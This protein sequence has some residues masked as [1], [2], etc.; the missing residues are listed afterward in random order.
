MPACPPWSRPCALADFL[1][2]L[3]PSHAIVAGLESLPDRATLAAMVRA[4]GPGRL[5]FSL[6]MQAGQPLTTAPAWRELSPPQIA[7]TALR[8]GVR[9][10]IVLDL[11]AVGVG[12][13]VGTQPLCRQLRCQ[14]AE[15]EII[16]G[17]GV[18]GPHDLASLAAAGAERSA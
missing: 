16:A 9:R 18:R 11:A 10:L 5:I 17:G 2:T 12:Q 8:A 4:V 13:G 1:D 3:G 14:D 6:D 15:L 7:T